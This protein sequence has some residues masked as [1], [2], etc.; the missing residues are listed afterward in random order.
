MVGIDEVGR[1]PLAG[2]VTVAAVTAT[3]AF[4]RSA[5]ALPV[6]L[7]DS[8]RLSPRQREAWFRHVRTEA[9][10]GTVRYAL[11]GVSAPVID[12]VNVTRAANRAATRAFKRLVSSMEY[13]VSGVNVILD[14]GL[15][16]NKIRDTKYKI[17]NTN[18][19][20]RG[21]ERF[22]A[23]ALASIIA[24]VSR[25]R[26]MGRFHKRFPAYGFHIHKG[27]GTPR[28]LRALKKHGPSKIHRLT[29]I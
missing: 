16:L 4:W 5:A 20:V 7:R 15:Y 26:T 25:D 10:R 1:G 11:A 19:V 2:P 21:D 28:H 8:K 29:F 14:G 24:K 17:L 13:K 12:R 3:E 22:P 27:Y 9:V 6:P 23:V 18:T